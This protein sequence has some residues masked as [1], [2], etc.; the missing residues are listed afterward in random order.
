MVANFMQELIL[1]PYA[2]LAFGFTQGQ[3]TQLS[4][5]QNGGVFVG[6]LTVGIAA[7]GL[8]IG[9]LQAWVMIGC[10]VV[11]RNPHLFLP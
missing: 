8:R 7:T 10:K 2:G 6:M 1:E 3:S 11:T 4:G 5:A 9:S